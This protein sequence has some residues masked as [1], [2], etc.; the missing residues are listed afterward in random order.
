ME[1]ID[2]CDEN[3]IPTGE[4]ENIVEQSLRIQKEE[5]EQV[6]LIT[7]KETKKITNGHWT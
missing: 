4:K 3:G 7:L 6:K 1:Y 2:V 5:V